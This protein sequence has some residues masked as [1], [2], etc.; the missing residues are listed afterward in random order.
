MKNNY[1]IKYKNQIIF[2][3]LF[4]LSPLLFIPL[5]IFY[6]K[7]NQSNKT[8]LYL[9]FLI[10]LSFGYI[11]FHTVPLISDDLYR[12]YEVMNNLKNLDIFSIW[13]YGYPLV[14]LNTFIMY[15]CSLFNSNLY[16]FFLI[17]IGMFIYFYLFNEL[18]KTFNISTYN[19]IFVL[20]FSYLSM[21]PRYYYSGL[22]NHFVLL[23]ISYLIYITFKKERIKKQD[24]LI[25]ILSCILLSLIHISSV[26]ILA[27]YI[28]YLVRENLSDKLKKIYDILMIF[29]SQILLLFTNLCYCLFPSL[30]NNIFFRKIYGYMKNFIYVQNLKQYIL[31]LIFIVLCIIV[32]YFVKGKQKKECLNKYNT[33]FYVFLLMTITMVPNMSI[34][35][36]FIYMLSYLIVPMI[37]Q[38]FTCNINKKF[39]FPIKIIMVLILIG[40]LIYLYKSIIAYPWIFDKNVLDLFFFA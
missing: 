32:F 33:F 30:I 6:L 38:L 11:A 10:A 14:P 17:F 23:I 22:R 39:I 5:G 34:L 18:N 26:L 20:T 15:I 8:S 35:I 27:I 9:I 24:T 31:F 12:H 16:P 25:F 40:N 7:K 3:L 1:L 4:F 29:G 37:Y 28:L 36:R 2:T 13:D 21:I 19:F